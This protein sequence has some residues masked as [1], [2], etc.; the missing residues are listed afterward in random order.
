MRPETLTTSVVMVLLAASAGSLGIRQAIESRART[1]SDSA[2]RSPSRTSFARPDSGRFGDRRE[3]LLETEDVDDRLKWAVSNRNPADRMRALIELTREFDPED[4]PMALETL[5]R[6]LHVGEGAEFHLVL[7]GWMRTDRDA[8]W[9]WAKANERGQNAVIQDWARE[10]PAGAVAAILEAEIGDKTRRSRLFQNALTAVFGNVDQYFE[11]YHA[12]PEDQRWEVLSPITL[13]RVEFTE[14]ACREWFERFGSE[15]GERFL[16][17]TV[18]LTDDLE[19][20]GRWIAAYPGEVPPQVHASVY[21]KW[22][23]EDPD[24]ALASLENLED[25]EAKKW[26]SYGAARW[27]IGKGDFERGYE[28]ANRGELDDSLRW[29]LLQGPGPGSPEEWGLLL[30][31]GRRFHDQG[32]WLRFSQQMLS[33]WN[34]KDAKAAAEWMAGHEVPDLVRREIEAQNRK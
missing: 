31:Q 33:E 9:E 22:V 20:Q 13:P 23:D 18:R 28:V 19:M 17:A 14:A 27:L 3:V 34:R 24:Q 5:G 21:E 16:K 6:L 8:A 11:A 12:I 25:A 2:E 4:W 15:D 1:E 26:A 30:D 7:A 29:D 10:D 32:R